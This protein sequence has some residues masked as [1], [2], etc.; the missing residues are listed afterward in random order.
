MCRASAALLADACWPGPLTLLVPK[1]EH[2]LS[3]VTGGRATVGVRVPA[4]PLTTELLATVRRRAGGAHR[5]TG[6]AW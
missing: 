1:A 5:P 3:V 2:V 4:H 6:S